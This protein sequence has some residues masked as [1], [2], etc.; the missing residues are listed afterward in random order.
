MSTAQPV[1]AGSEPPLRQ[2]GKG[3]TSDGSDATMK[4]E[5]QEQHDGDGGSGGGK[6]DAAPLSVNAHLLVAAVF[7]DLLAVALVVP[8]LPIRFKQLGVTPAM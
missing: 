5:K 7:A 4:Q 1:A 6:E 8:L 3:S 2:R